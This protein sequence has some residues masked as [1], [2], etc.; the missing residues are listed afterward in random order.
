MHTLTLS[1]RNK[2]HKDQ[3]TLLSLEK[4]PTGKIF[5]V[6]H[7]NSICIP[8]E[9]VQNVVPILFATM[10]N[11]TSIPS[12][13]YPLYSGELLLKQFVFTFHST[14]L[15]IRAVLNYFFLNRRGNKF[16]KLCT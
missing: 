13:D 16:N 14:N 4:S 5:S 10:L 1:L 3:S 9:K 6:N 7:L 15:T 11:A 8:V 2:A 12:Y